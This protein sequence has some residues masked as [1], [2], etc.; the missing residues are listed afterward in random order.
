MI[1]IGLTGGIC[2]GK[3]FVLD[4]F[5]ELGCY[6]LSADKIA[7]DIIF[8]ENFEILKKIKSVFGEDIYSEENGLDKERFSKSLFE[9]TKKR[10]FINNFIHPLVAKERDK[11]YNDLNK[12]GIKGF[13][14]YESAL[15]VEA[16]I[17][18]NFDKIIVTYTSSDEQLKRLME[19]DR[20]EPEMAEKMIK[21]QFPL[22]EK[23][24]VADFTIDTTGTMEEAKRRALETYYLLKNSFKKDNNGIAKG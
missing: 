15:L 2:T 7:K 5:K 13:F 14:V 16:G 23:L 19:R 22:R 10:E 11:V 20:I 12:A 1:K 6:T 4:L 18:K 3:T 24:K 8:S 9:D 17:F 21:A